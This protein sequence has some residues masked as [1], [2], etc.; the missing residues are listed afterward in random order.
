MQSAKHGAR[1]R[2]RRDRVKRDR[3][4]TVSATVLGRSTARSRISWFAC[5]A[6]LLLVTSGCGAGG[7]SSKRGLQYGI[8]LSAAQLPAKAIQARRIKLASAPVRHGV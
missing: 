3:R 2:P 7:S 6:V 1:D 8:Q 5:L 4:A